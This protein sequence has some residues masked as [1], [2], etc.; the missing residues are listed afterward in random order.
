MVFFFKK[1]PEI[2]IF[3]K[4]NGWT[5]VNEGGDFFGF[6]FYDEWYFLSKLFFCERS[7]FRAVYFYISTEPRW[8]T[9]YTV[10]VV[11][12]TSCGIRIKFVCTY[13]YVCIYMSAILAVSKSNHCFDCFFIH[14][15]QLLILR[16]KIWTAVEI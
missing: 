2:E 11:T 9:K 13:V 15:H 10:K 7:L 1:I 6:A 5:F 14:H 3:V 8:G 12:I 4:K 16:R